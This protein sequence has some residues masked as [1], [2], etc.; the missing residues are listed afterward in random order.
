MHSTFS[1]QMG[2]IN[3]FL[4]TIALSRF[5]T[6]KNSELAC[7]NF[8][9][10]AYISRLFFLNWL[11]AGRLI[12]KCK[13]CAWRRILFLCTKAEALQSQKLFVFS[14]KLFSFFSKYIGDA[15]KGS[16][17]LPAT[18][19]QKLFLMLCAVNV[20][21]MYS[22]QKK[23]N[24]EFYLSNSQTKTRGRKMAPFC[25]IAR[26]NI[27]LD[28]TNVEFCLVKSSKSEMRGEIV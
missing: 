3:Y 10:R 18:N 24:M 27:R 15:Q 21:L 8:K 2:F 1:P 28:I 13:H 12:I 5:N 25:S 23:I 4:Y 17:L 19:P 6:Y 14:K 7:A 11:N 26:F 22:A 9:P 20:T 16:T